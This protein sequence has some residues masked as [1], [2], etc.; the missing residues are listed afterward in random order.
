MK[1][2]PF[3]AAA[4]CVIASAASIPRHALQ[5][6]VRSIVARQPMNPARNDVD[7]TGSHFEHLD[8]GPD[9]TQPVQGKKR[10]RANEELFPSGKVRRLTAL[11]GVTA[12]ARHK[13]NPKAIYDYNDAVYEFPKIAE[14]FTAKLENE[15][16]NTNVLVDEI[17]QKIFHINFLR[18]DLGDDNELVQYVEVTFKKTLNNA[19][20]KRDEASRNY[21]GQ[22]GNPK[23]EG[24]IHDIYLGFKLAILGR[25][26]E[27]ISL[28]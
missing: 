14:D 13:T 9:N 16:E 10:L 23:T 6:S 19:E 21:Y 3:V 24:A 4:L 25:L 27:I 12:P 8:I 22:I 18:E 5:T 11:S 1:T 2:F 28:Q 26:G 7:M 20:Q 17:Y 15:P